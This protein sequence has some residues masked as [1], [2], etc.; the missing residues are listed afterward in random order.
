MARL[1]TLA[2]LAL[3]TLARANG[4]A[5]Q[6][7]L[8]THDQSCWPPAHAFAALQAHLSHPLVWPR[9]TAWPCYPPAHP[10]GDCA[11]VQAQ[12]S[13]GTW[14]ASQPGALEMA[15]WEPFVGRNG[16]VDACFLDTSLSGT[17]AQ[18]RVSVVGVDARTVADV[19]A[20]IAFAVQ[21]TLKLVVK[22]TGCVPLS[23]VCDGHDD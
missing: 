23:R 16:T 2:A 3:A 1:I 15:N 10:A 19:Q 11:E 22:N 12:W 7:C 5:T 9:P 18:G 13:N 20:A 8:C 4:N 6:Q 14:R 21:H 17:C